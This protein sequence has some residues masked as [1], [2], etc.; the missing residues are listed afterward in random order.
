MK[1]GRGE[2]A[3]RLFE[4]FEGRGGKGV[5][6]CPEATL[7]AYHH[8]LTLLPSPVAWSTYPILA[9]SSKP[10]K[11]CKIHLDSHNSVFG[12]NFQF[13]EGKPTEYIM[14]WVMP[15]MGGEGGERLRADVWKFTVAR[16]RRLGRRCTERVVKRLEEGKGREVERGVTSEE[17]TSGGSE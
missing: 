10:C 16:V 17:V 6:P 7:L 13:L 3:G 2:V 11:P 15:G 9:T 1:P 8:A 5:R 4:R 14:P 12:S